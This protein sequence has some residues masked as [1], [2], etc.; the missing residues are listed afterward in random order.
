MGP[1]ILEN[2]IRIM[3]R[4]VSAPGSQ[5]E[6]L[7]A[8]MFK[9]LI[10]SF[11]AALVAADHEIHPKQ[12]SS[13]FLLSHLSLA[14]CEFGFVEKQRGYRPGRTSAVEF[15]K[16]CSIR[17][18]RSDYNILLR[19]QRLLRAF[20][21]IVKALDPGY[22][23]VVQ[24]HD[25]EFPMDDFF[26]SQLGHVGEPGSTAPPVEAW[27]AG[28]VLTSF[29]GRLESIDYGGPVWKG[30][31]ALAGSNVQVECVFEK[32]SGED[33]INQ[34]GNKLV[35]V[36]GRAIYTGDSQL[37]E[38]LVVSRIEP[39]PQAGDVMDLGKSPAMSE[40]K[41]RGGELEQFP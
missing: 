36:S 13:D 4:P 23:V 5:P 9:K 20:H 32:S 34:F 10:D 28:A 21:R 35:R 41:D 37:P 15:F 33:A 19:Y 1:S 16:R 8:P 31:L 17:V 25:T 3:I 11:L 39:F 38:R 6:L 14:P 22:V 7:P 2:E 12:G 30:R 18:N 24:Y 29:Q 26:C 27:F 40:A